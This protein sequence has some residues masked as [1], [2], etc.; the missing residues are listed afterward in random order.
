MVVT[1]LAVLVAVIGV[2]NVFA[3]SSTSNSTHYQMTQTQFGASS[4]TQT[5]SAS[6]CSTT[7]I[8]ETAAGTSTSSAHTATFGP[9]TDSQPTLEVIVDPGSSDLGD[10]STTSTAMKTATVKVLSYLSNGYFVQVTGSPP[11]YGGH[12]LFTPSTPTAST[13]GTEQFG[14]NLVANSSPSLGTDPIQ[15]PSSQF[16]FGVLNSGYDTANEFMYHDG[17]TVAHSDSSSGETDYTISFIVNI[18]NLTPSGHYSGDYS[19]VVIPQY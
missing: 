10:L 8:G 18:S 9:V 12:T 5:C 11:K 1:L 3:E 17:D 16:S 7:S 2:H 4:A 15:V 13:I 6:Y 14:I 19:A